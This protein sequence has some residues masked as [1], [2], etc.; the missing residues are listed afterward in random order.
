M[1]YPSPTP[2]VCMV[3][4]VTPP[5]SNAWRTGV[6]EW[7]RVWQDGTYVSGVVDDRSDLAR[8][9]PPKSYIEELFD[10]T[11]LK[12]DTAYASIMEGLHEFF[13]IQPTFGP[14]NQN[15]V[16]MLRAPAVAVPHSLPGQLEYIRTHWGD[17]LGEF[18]RRL[19][20][21]LDLIR[22]ES[23]A[24]FL[25]PG[26]A[27]VHD[28]AGLE[29]EVRRLVEAGYGWEL[30]AMS[31]LGYV[32]FE[33]YFEGKATLEDVVTEIKRAT[34]RFIR[35]QYNWFRPGDPAIRWFDASETT[36]REIED[37]IKVWREPN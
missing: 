11:A 33:P 5:A 9:S 3:P 4:T 6:D 16:D 37:A 25:G 2:N 19:L 13:E 29:G 12:K 1:T 30:P 14:E 15:L 10:E 28:F 26:P 31:G 23:K 24:A 36:A 34:R 8:Y 7:G 32:Q 18:L 22:E 27:A 20:R 35:Q 17:L 21:S